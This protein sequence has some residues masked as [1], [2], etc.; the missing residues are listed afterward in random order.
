MTKAQA[1][2]Y[3]RRQG[4]V[5]VTDGDNLTDARPATASGTMPLPALESVNLAAQSARGA[6]AKGLRERS[7]IWPGRGTLTR[8]LPHGRGDMT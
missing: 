1:E 8:V 6:F 2:A 5:Y 7:D 4:I 3:C